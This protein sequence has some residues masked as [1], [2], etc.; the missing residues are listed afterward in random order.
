[1]FELFLSQVPQCLLYIAQIK[2]SEN[3]FLPKF[4]HIENSRRAILK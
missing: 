4:I 2:T 3:L 1:M